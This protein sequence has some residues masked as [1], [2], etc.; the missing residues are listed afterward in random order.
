MSFKFLSRFR[1]EL[2]RN[3]QSVLQAASQ[4]LIEPL[5]VMGEKFLRERIDIANCFSKNTARE[6]RPAALRGGQLEVCSCRRLG[7]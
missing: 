3:V 7:L 2:N 5:K 1:I 4:H 6:Y